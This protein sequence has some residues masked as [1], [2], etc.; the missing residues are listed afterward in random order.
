MAVGALFND[1]NGENSGHVCVSEY[2]GFPIDD[3]IQVGQGIDGEAAF[4]QSGFSVSLSSSASRLAVGAPMNSD[5][6]SLSGHVLVHTLEIFVDGF[7]SG[8]PSAWSVTVP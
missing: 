7:E 3:W 4:D 6:G 5:N 8:D 2:R 1:G